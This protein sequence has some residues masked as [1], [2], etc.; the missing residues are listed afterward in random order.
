MTQKPCYADYVNHMLRVYFKTQDAGQDAGQDSMQD[1]AY[2]SR[3]NQ[4][5]PN[6]NHPSRDRPVTDRSSL[7]LVNRRACDRVIGSLTPADRET[8]RTVYSMHSANITACVNGYC[9]TTNTDRRTAWRLIR[10]VCADVARERG[11][12]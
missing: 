7:D 6:Q 5:R 2:P 11:L 1:S 9:D 8:V 3:Q 10:H 12:I 4:N